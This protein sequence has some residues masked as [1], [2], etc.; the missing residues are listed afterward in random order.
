M[1]YI[2][3]V[4]IEENK[5]SVLFDNKKVVYEHN[6]LDELQLA[7]ACTIHKSQGSEFPVVIMPVSTSHYIMLQRNLIYTGI[8]RAKRLCIMMGT[9]QALSIAVQ[10]NTVPLRNSQLKERIIAAADGF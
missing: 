5:L 10:N 7:Y 9:T 8:T 3:T 1:G 4:D 2:Q 6:E